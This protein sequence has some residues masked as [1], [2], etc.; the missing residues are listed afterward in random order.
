MTGKLLSIPFFPF[1]MH[2][3]LQGT[4]ECVCKCFVGLSVMHECG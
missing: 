3:G 2:T 1:G 4:G